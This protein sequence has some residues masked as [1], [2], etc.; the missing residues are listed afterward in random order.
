MME[1][2]EHDHCFYILSQD[3]ESG[4]YRLEVECGTTAVFTVTIKLNDREIAM[5]LQ[6]K[7]SIRTLA[8]KILDYPSEYISRQI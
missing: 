6:D 1:I 3:K 7:E 2:L 5:Y 4:E 8:Y